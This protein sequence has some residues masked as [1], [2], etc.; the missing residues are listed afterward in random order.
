MNQT[1]GFKW[2]VPGLLDGSLGCGGE[3]SAGASFLRRDGNGRNAP[4]IAR[5]RDRD[6]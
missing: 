5:G 2:F 6:R 1:V 4:S 3:E